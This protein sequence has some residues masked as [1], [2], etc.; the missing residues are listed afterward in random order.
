MFRRG[1]TRGKGP[2]KS[3]EPEYEEVGP[4][5]HL[6]KPTDQRGDEQNC[7]LCGSATAAVRCD[8]CGS[9]A[10][11]LSCDDM[12]HRHPRRSTHVR[13]AVDVKTGAGGVVRPPLPPKGDGQQPAVPP[14]QPP[15]RKNKRAGFLSNSSFSKKDQSVTGS[16]GG[17]GEGNSTG[18]T[19]MGSLKRFMGARPLPPT[20][21]QVKGGVKEESTV[22]NSS[23]N[24]KGS[25]SRATTSPSLPNLNDHIEDEIRA[26]L[27]ESVLDYNQNTTPLRNNSVSTPVT[28]ASA[29][30]QYPP[31]QPPKTSQPQQPPANTH[32]LGRKFSLQQLPQSFDDKRTR[33]EKKKLNVR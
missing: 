13:K 18:R 2:G 11:C 8:R 23:N 9:Q 19:I 7:E 20:P 15:P 24:N 29:H 33:F 16:G 6:K 32:S 21:D 12:F 28:P 30:T 27:P 25:L 31:L 3:N 14:P 26:G 22:T 5:R 4:P 10:F 1:L 17:G